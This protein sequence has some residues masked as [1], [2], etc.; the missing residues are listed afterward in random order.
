MARHP[1]IKFSLPPIFIFSQFFAISLIL[2]SQFSP[3]RGLRKSYIKTNYTIGSHTAVAF[4]KYA[5]YLYGTMASRIKS[6]KS[7]ENRT[8]FL[9]FKKSGFIKTSK[10]R[11]CVRTINFLDKSNIVEDVIT[12]KNEFACV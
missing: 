12:D 4:Q 6:G 7:C 5:I 3:L 10:T 11:G 1:K 2:F 9:R 8:N